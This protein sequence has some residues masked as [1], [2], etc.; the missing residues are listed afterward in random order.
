MRSDPHY[1]AAVEGY[2]REALAERAGT[3]VDY[4]DRLVELGILAGPEAA[5]TFYH[6]QIELPLLHVGMSEGQVMLAANEAVAAG[7]AHVDRALIALYHGQSEH[8]W[9][10]GVIEG[11]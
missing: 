1:H 6:A 8:T 10:A 3:S 4:V 9:L 7:I 5:S 2:T 11:V